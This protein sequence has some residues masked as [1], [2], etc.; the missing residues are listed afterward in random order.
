MI[1]LMFVDVAVTTFHAFRLLVKTSVTFL[2]NSS[3]NVL[4]VYLLGSVYNKLQK[5]VSS[6]QFNIQRLL[7]SENDSVVPVPAV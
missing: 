5:S 3:N 2:I 4:F 6:V 1:E 7:Y